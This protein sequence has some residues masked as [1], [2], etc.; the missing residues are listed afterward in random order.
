VRFRAWTEEMLARLQAELGDVER[1]GHPT[2]RLPHTLNVYIPGVE[3]RALIVQLPDVAIATGSACTSASVEPSHVIAALGY[4]DIR[5]H[6]SI[7]IS[8]GRFI[9]EEVAYKACQKIAHISHKLVEIGKPR[10]T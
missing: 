6:C 7:R 2:Q 9:N 3:S 1:N 10:H 4:E 5:A 8:V